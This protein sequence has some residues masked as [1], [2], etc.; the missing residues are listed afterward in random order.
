MDG[1]EQETVDLQWVEE[2]FDAGPEIDAVFRAQRRLSFAYGGAFLIVTL[3]IPFLSVFS[4]YWTDVAVLGSFSLN[5]L[6]VTA[7]YHVVYVLMGAAY[8][9]QANRLEQELLGRRLPP[10]RRGA[11][12]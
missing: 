5:F 3:S 4:R 12:R 7:I 8:A 10:L 9:L 6:V 2:E 1:V 11:S